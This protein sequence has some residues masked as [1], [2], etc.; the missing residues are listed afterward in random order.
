LT[1]SKST[2]VYRP[3]PQDDPRVRRPDIR[4]AQDLLRWKSK[5]SLESGLRKTI[6]FFKKEPVSR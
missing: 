3:L 4:K 1:R 5:V 2:I 6:S